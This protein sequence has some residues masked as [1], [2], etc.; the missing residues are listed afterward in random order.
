MRSAHQVRRS[1]G[2][3]AAGW[4]T[5]SE[6]MMRDLNTRRVL[7]SFNG[8]RVLAGV[9]QGEAVVVALPLSSQSRLVQN[10]V[11]PDPGPAWK[12]SPKGADASGADRC[13]QCGDKERPVLGVI[14]VA[15]GL[16]SSESRRAGR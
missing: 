13:S 7:Q 9:I 11:Y 3:M 4:S 10:L 8:L 1:I 6:S 15:L 16:V 12:V 2:S 14:P 5:G